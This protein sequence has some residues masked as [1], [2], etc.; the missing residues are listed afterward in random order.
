MKNNPAGKVELYNLADD[1]S[2]ETDLSG[3][4]PDKVEAFTRLMIESRDE[5]EIERF[6]F[7]KYE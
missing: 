5:P 1:P 7:W 3:K 2:E 6:R 4:H